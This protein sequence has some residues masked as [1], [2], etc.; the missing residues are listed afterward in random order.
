MQA[1][2]NRNLA[3]RNVRGLRVRGLPARSTLKTGP[4]AGFPGASSPRALRQGISYPGPI[5]A[6]RFEH[7]IKQ[8]PPDNW[9]GLDLYRAPE[10]RRKGN[11]AGTS[12]LDRQIS[13]CGYA[14]DAALTSASRRHFWSGGCIHVWQTTHVSLGSACAAGRG[15]QSNPEKAGRRQMPLAVIWRLAVFSLPQTALCSPP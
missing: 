4:R 8:F 7:T 2:A 6:N 9:T 12:K 3:G 11:P 15:L 5:R 1:F 14:A 10:I 13:F